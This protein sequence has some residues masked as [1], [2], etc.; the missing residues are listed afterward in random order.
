MQNRGFIKDDHDLSFRV[1]RTDSAANSKSPAH[2]KSFVSSTKLIIKPTLEVFEPSDKNEESKTSKYVLEI[3][4]ST[5][6]KPSTLDTL[7]PSSED[8]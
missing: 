2:S 6:G 7:S 8:S 3:Y 1:K 5:K 4:P